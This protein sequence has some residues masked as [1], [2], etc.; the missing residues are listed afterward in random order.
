MTKR[1]SQPRVDPEVANHM[2][3]AALWS[4]R[5]R[6]AGADEHL[7]A[8]F[9]EWCG[10]DPSKIKAFQQ[11]DAAWHAARSVSE[12]PDV[13]RLRRDVLARAAA[14]KRPVLSAPK[15][16]GVAA[17]VL[18]CI[19]FGFALAHIALQRPAPPSPEIIADQAAFGA[20][21]YATL[22]GE[23]LTT[24]LPDGSTMTLSTSSRARVAFS[25]DERRIELID[26]QVFFDVAHG[27][28]R[29]FVVLAAGRR[30]TALGTAFEVRVETSQISV[31]L[32]EGHVVVDAPV[33]DEPAPSGAEAASR[34]AELAPGEQ[35]V[36][37]AQAPPSIEDV[38]T[39]RVTSWL[40]GW[41]VFED[42]PLSTAIAEM[43]RYASRPIIIADDPL[44]ARRVSG[45]FKA[46]RSSELVE[47]LAEYFPD[48]QVRT[49]DQAIVLTASG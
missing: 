7:Q 21:E 16:T 1:S 33:L 30:V 38:D 12:C 35:L 11:A 17:G 45:A 42:E 14:D 5:L 48:V 25:G 23:R 36:Q 22:T 31:T 13:M 37:I 41:L 4:E 19:G 46:G 20:M 26:G 43:N 39:R 44:K 32:V 27:D 15:L 18:V 3:A 6:E 8:L 10:D 2:Q 40:D 34:R 24:P 29:A 9:E 28:P 49:S 47:A